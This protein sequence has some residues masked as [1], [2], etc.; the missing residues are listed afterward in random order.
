MGYEAIET[1]AKAI[2]ESLEQG[3]VFYTGKAYNSF[4]AAV[5]NLVSM[6]DQHRDSY[7]KEEPNERVAEGV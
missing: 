3:E 4:K 6:V 2:V 5:N 1:E 7:L